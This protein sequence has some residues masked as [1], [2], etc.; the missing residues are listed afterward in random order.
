LIFIYLI[1]GTGMLRNVT[2]SLI[3]KDFTK[4]VLLI[5]RRASTFASVNLLQNNDKLTTIDFDYSIDDTQKLFDTLENFKI[6]LALLWIH[7]G[8]CGGKQFQSLLFQHLLPPPDS[9]HYCRIFSIK[10]S[11]HYE[12]NTEQ[13][14]LSEYKQFHQILL[15]FVLLDDDDN[16]NARWLH[17]NEISQGVLNALEPSKQTFVIGTIEPVSRKPR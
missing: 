10:G 3:Q 8:D 15:G 9:K 17:D 4:N 7:E 14:Y 11:S 16:R 6:D 13:S 5:S 1:G 2:L 12:N